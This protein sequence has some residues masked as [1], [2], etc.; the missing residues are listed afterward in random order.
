MGTRMFILPL[1]GYPL[2]ISDLYGLHFTMPQKYWVVVIQLFRMI[3]RALA[4]NR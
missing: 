4:A 3:D 2:E 1:L